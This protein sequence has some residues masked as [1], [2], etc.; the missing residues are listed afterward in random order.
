MTTYFF[1]RAF[2]LK[3]GVF[4]GCQFE[5]G[6]E[7]LHTLIQHGYTFYWNDVAFNLVI[8]KTKKQQ[9]KLLFNDYR[10]SSCVNFEYLPLNTLLQ[11][12]SRGLLYW[13]DEQISQNRVTFKN[14]D[15]R[16]NSSLPMHLSVSES[17]WVRTPSW[18]EMFNSLPHA[19][20]RIKIS[21]FTTAY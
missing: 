14:S 3:K 17:L 13:I 8:K 20:P 19:H 7:S 1:N 12:F 5:P 21:S 2:N 16:N 4:N 11:C 18:A 10:I 6:F 15:I 9:I